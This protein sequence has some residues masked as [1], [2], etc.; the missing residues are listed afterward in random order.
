MTETVLAILNQPSLDAAPHDPN[1]D[2]YTFAGSL[3]EHIQVMDFG[4]TRG[5]GIFET[6]T[7]TNGRP[8]A[9]EAHLRRFV[10]SASLLDLPTPDVD[11]WRRAIEAVVAELDPVPE[12]YVKTVLTRGVEGL[13]RPTGWA[14]GA[15]SADSTTARTEG[16]AVV[17]L[18]RGY[19]H[20]VART[21]PWLLQ[22]AKTLSYAVNMAAV[23]E[24]K[25]RGADDVVFVSTDGYVLEGPT[26]TLV[27]LVDGRLVT[28]RTDIGIL[29]G[30]TQADLFRFAEGR[31]IQTSYEL[32]TV[33][34][35]VSADAV[36][37]VSSVR[38]AAP[39]RSI[40]GDLHD[41][42]HDLTDAMNEFLLAREA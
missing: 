17:T 20:D 2:T 19:R 36:W 10:H 6:I 16:I 9:L 42:D 25:R 39:I 11:A 21:S 24:A 23:R 7:V 8:Q 32:V 38:Q 18:D 3:E 1:A 28:P 12:A 13:G 41:I 27:L 34:D 4:I 5:D 26:S 30:T 14:Y 37:L 40:N 35:F 22:G 31:G 33:N 15:P 29:E